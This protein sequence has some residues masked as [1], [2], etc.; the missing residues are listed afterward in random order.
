MKLPLRLVGRLGG[1]TGAG[2]GAVMMT[3]GCDLGVVANQRGR[4]SLWTADLGRQIWTRK[5]AGWSAK[6]R[7]CGDRLLV[8]PVGGV[9]EVLELVSGDVRNQIPCDLLAGVV[10]AD[11][12]LLILFGSGKLIALDLFGRVIWERPG[13]ISHIVQACDDLFLTDDRDTRLVCLSLKTDAERWAFR[14]PPVGDGEAGKRSRIIPAGFPS[15][16]VVG[17]S[18]VV[19]AMDARVFRITAAS[20]EILTEGQAPMAGPFTTSQESLFFARDYELSI[21]SHSEMRETERVEFRSSVQPLYRGRTPSILGIA[22]AG[23]SLFWSTE[24]SSLMGVALRPDSAGLRNTWHWEMPGAIIPI[25]DGPVPA[26]EYL[27]F[28]KKGDD[29]ELLCFGEKNLG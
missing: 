4:V 23:E 21:F 29:P 14:I 26:D 13:L 15:V 3:L 27:Y 6:P 16:S 12:E 24:Y 7:L 22:V 8:G 20:G 2:K 11:S 10:A 17:D 19:V 18:L 5:V 9:V 1:D 25:S 28:S